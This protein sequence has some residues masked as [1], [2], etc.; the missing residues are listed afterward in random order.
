M[1]RDN[2]MALYKNLKFRVKW[3]GRDVGGTSKLGKSRLPETLRKVLR[4][5]GS[6]LR[7]GAA[8]LDDS[9]FS[10]KKGVG[11]GISVLFAGE[12]GTGKRMAAEVLA[13]NLQLDLYHIDLASVVNKYIGE[14]E[15]N[16]RRI[17][18]AAEES[19]PVLFF[20]EGEAFFGKRS[21]VKD[22]HDRYVNIELNYLLRQMEEY[23]GL[24]ILSTD[25][26]SDFDPVFLARFRFVVKFPVPHPDPR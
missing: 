26:K 5:I 6:H 19:G 1:L 20:D 23:R 25:Y 21:E 16:L 15:K 11:R 18:D 10:R 12:T 14:T 13:N 2:R 4:E 9:G 3:E 22:G 7:H 8:V 24:V 17:F